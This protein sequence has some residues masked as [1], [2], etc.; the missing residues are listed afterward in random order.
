MPDIYGPAL[1]AWLDEMRGA[2]SVRSFALERGLDDARIS[3]WRRGGTPTLEQLRD[4]A[5]AVNVHLGDVLIAAGLARP[6]ELVVSEPR[7][8]PPPN[9]D[10]AISRDP[11]LTDGEREIL[12]TVRKVAKDAAAGQ[13][14]NTRQRIEVRRPG[15][16][17][18][19]H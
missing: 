15:R 6:D 7:E 3:A 18:K 17:R 4:V 14:R 9:I 12:R 11:S 13:A 19:G 1:A 5:D 8:A 10:D 2:Q 16:N